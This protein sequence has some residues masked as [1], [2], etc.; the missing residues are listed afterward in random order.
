MIFVIHDLG[1]AAS[2]TCKFWF[3]DPSESLSRLLQEPDDQ[4]KGKRVTSRPAICPS[5]LG[6]NSG[7][8]DPEPA[9]AP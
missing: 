6:S 9:G 2:H 8:E 4:G 7:P 1:A 5:G 3:D